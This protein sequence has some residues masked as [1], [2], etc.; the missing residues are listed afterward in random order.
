M[1]GNSINVSND[2]VLI[3]YNWKMW[4]LEYDGT[5]PLMYPVND[6]PDWYC[7]I[8]TRYSNPI[9]LVLEAHQAYAFYQGWCYSNEGRTIYAD[10]KTSRAS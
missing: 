3:T 6:R 10:F 2:T 8:G 7:V 4:R 1:S 5:Q 9:P